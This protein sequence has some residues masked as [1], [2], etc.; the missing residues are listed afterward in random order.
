LYVEEFKIDASKNLTFHEQNT[1]SDYV[2][3]E[4]FEFGNATRVNLT[5]QTLVDMVNTT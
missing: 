2:I 3:A 1:L 5:N 4:H